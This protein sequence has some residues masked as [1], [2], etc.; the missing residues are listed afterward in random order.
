[1]LFVDERFLKCTKSV[2]APLCRNKPVLFRLS[3]PIAKSLSSAKSKLASVRN[4]CTLFSR[5]Y[6]ACQARDGNL[7]EFFA[8]ENQS[9]PPSL[10][11]NGKL[12]FGTKSDLLTCLEK[13]VEPSLDS[14]HVDMLV[15][16][17]AAITQMLHPTDCK[18]FHEYASNVFL[19]YLRSQLRNVDQLDLV[20][21]RYLVD[22]L[23]ARTREK[24]GTGVRRHLLHCQKIGLT[25]YMLMKISKNCFLFCHSAHYLQILE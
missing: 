24:R 19:P 23:N 15:L 5:L 10:S 25:F 9:F 8:H 20:W 2:T 3:A 18:T 16:D 1:M 13:L 12:R 6:I 17:G 14:P 11:V 21:N 7:D 22:S 4:D